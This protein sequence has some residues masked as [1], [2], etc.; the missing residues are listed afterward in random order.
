MQWVLK[1]HSMLSRKQINE[2]LWNKLPIDFGDDQKFGRIGNLLTKMRKNGLIEADENR[3]WHLSDFKW[4]LSEIRQFFEYVFISIF[5]KHLI[6]RR[7]FSNEENE[8]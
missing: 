8:I 1:D 5:I 6:I 2:L 4:D 7:F 3:L